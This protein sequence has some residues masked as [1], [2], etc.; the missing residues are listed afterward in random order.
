[1][2][3]HSSGRFLKPP[4]LPS[5]LIPTHPTPQHLRGWGA[6]QAP[7]SDP[8]GPA[9][10]TGREGPSLPGAKRTSPHA[11]E[12][13]GPAGLRR[14][15]SWSDTWQESASVKVSGC[16]GISAG[17]KPSAGRPGFLPTPGH[18]LAV[19]LGSSPSLRSSFLF[20]ETGVPSRLRL[21]RSQPLRSPCL[22]RPKDPPP[23]P[24]PST[25]ADARQESLLMPSAPPLLPTRA[26]DW[27][28]GPGR[29]S[30][31]RADALGGAWTEP[32][33]APFVRAAAVR[34]RVGGAR[35]DRAARSLSSG[36]GCRPMARGSARAQPQGAAPGR[37]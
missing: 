19:T 7:H 35:G 21:R 22:H 9:A 33:P 1:M 26:P 32:A 3:S 37:G 11:D 13:K 29:D 36:S 27:W 18:Q 30:G 5:A 15:G 25:R 4:G 24:V 28:T 16:A 6:A 23:P 2:T 14:R 17:G 34:A 12:P 10:T 31:A 8:P 20:Y